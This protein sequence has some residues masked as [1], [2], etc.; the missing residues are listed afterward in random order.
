MAWQ[1]A[2]NIAQGKVAK[3]GDSMTGPLAMGDN[4]ITGVADGANAGD[5]AT[6]AQTFGGAPLTLAADV[7]TVQPRDGRIISGTLV[8]DVNGTVELDLDMSCLVQ[9]IAECRFVFNVAASTVAFPLDDGTVQNNLA[10]VTKTLVATVNASGPV[11]N[12]AQVKASLVI[13]GCTKAAPLHVELRVGGVGYGY[14]MYLPSPAV[15]P[16]RVLLSPDRTKGYVGCT[17]GHVV[18]F[19]MARDMNNYTD[20]PLPAINVPLLTDIGFTADGTKLWWCAFYG[21]QVGIIDTTSDQRTTTISTPGDY[22]SVLAV[23]ADGVA[24]VVSTSGNLLAYNLDGSQKS[25]TALP[26]LGYV[27]VSA[28]GTKLACAIN[29]VVS[30]IDITGTPTVLASLT[31]TGADFRRPQWEASGSSAFWVPDHGNGRLQRYTFA[32]S[33]IA[34][35][36]TT[37]STLTLASASALAL[38]PGRDASNTLLSESDE[39][40][41]GVSDV[42]PN[43][44][45]YYWATQKST[46]NPGVRFDGGPMTGGA[47]TDIVAD[48]DGAIYYART[49]DNAVYDNFGFRFSCRPNTWAEHLTITPKG[50]HWQ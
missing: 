31:V 10:G 47:L 38:L 29:G 25:T 41:F 35:S 15:N 13:E 40:I 20:V 43:G 9:G 18:P 39:T 11:G 6:V 30:V 46:D 2:G 37:G 7:V 49:G 19:F 21:Q 23:G 34:A 5:V 42:T 16:T 48:G 8:P 24:W 32:G 3:S 4:P 27:A 26:N 17:S 33:T 1:S 14:L 45:W 12:A 22:P 44:Y 28:D 50:A 36:A